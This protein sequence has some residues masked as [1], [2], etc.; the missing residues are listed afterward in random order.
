MSA[1]PDR[2]EGPTPR[3]VRLARLRAELD[4]RFRGALPRPSQPRHGA[5]PS[6]WPDVD[7]ALAGGL[8]HGETALLE[9]PPGSGALALASDWA[10]AASASGEH[11]LVVDTTDT[12]L[13]HA[14][15]PPPAGAPIWRVAPL[16][17]AEAWVALDIALRAGGFGLLALLDAPPMP[18][19]AGRRLRHLLR[20]S[21]SRLLLTGPPGP[22]ALEGLVPAASLALS[23]GAVHWRHAPLGSVPRARALTFHAPTRAP[24][25]TLREDLLSNR[26]RPRP[27]APDR[28]PS[29]H[30]PRHHA[31]PRRPPG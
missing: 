5:L 13:P 6:G 7:A 18:R 9:A 30:P 28:R 16:H 23:A 4:A 14:W 24:E 12:T 15:V 17:P 1:R 10:R 27:R 25:V 3:Q 2:L 11:A 29:R 22:R 21:R 8:A 31:A 26:L 20:G 19:R